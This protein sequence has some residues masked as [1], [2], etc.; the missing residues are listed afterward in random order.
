[1]SYKYI[2]KGVYTLS[3]VYKITNISK[4]KLVRWIR[5]YTYYRNDKAFKVHPFFTADY[6]SAEAGLTF[7][8]LD[9]I[10]LLFINS[11]A[12]RGVSLQTIRLAADRASELLKTAHP[13]AQKIFYT[14][15]KTIFAEIAIKHN[16]S[17]LLDLIKKQYQFEKI[18]EP[19]L[20]RCLDFDESN[21][22]S[23][24]WPLGKKGRIVIDPE[25][26]FGKPIIDS[27][28]IKVET[29][30][31][32]VRRNKSVSEIADWYDIDCES[33]YAALDYSE[34]VPA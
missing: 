5:G 32:L 24:W 15:G 17:D 18:L 3:D 27:L 21:A 25:R 31:D 20:Y 34:R 11:F 28:N 23:R 22:A 12:T 4:Q 6:Q 9:V 7:S 2:G 8:F 30:V 1:M 29:I 26:N 10:E 33:I 14:D 16:E 19:L 13:F